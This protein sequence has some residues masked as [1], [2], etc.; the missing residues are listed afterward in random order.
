MATKDKLVFRWAKMKEEIDHSGKVV[1]RAPALVYFCECCMRFLLGALLSGAELFGGY[2][3][4][5]VGLVA[6]SGSGL[7]GFCAL[8]GAC[9]GY[10]SFQ[11]FVGGLRYVAAAILVFSVS[12]AFFDLRLYRLS[13]FM[14]VL[15]GLM[16]AATGFVYLSEAGWSQ[17]SIVYFLTEVVLTGVSCYFYA[18][19]LATWGKGR[20][21]TGVTYHQRISI[22][23]LLGTLLLTVT[24]LTLFQHLSV[25]HVVAAVVVMI[26]SYQG[27]LTGGALVGVTVGIGL[28][29][30]VESYSIYAMSYGLSGVMAGIAHR[31]GRG[32]CG[33]T[34][35]LS[36]AL[37]ILWMWAILPDV[38][39]LYEVFVAV[40]CFVLIPEPLL[41]QLEDLWKKKE[42]V[43]TETKSSSYVKD[44]LCATADGFRALHQ[45][46]LHA[47][48]YPPPNDND[49][50]TIFDRVADRVC[51]TCLL[52]GNCWH[53]DYVSTYNALNDALPTM[54]DRGSGESGDFPQ[55]FTHR[56]IHFADFLGASN[57]ELT[58]LRYRQQYQS[59]LLES[60]QAVC[61]QY[62][63]LAETLGQAVAQLEGGLV[64]DPV[65]SKK[66]KQHL[67]SR[68]ME[69]DSGV[70]REEG[71][72]L[73]L[74]LATSRLA[75]LT[76][77][78]GASALSK[79]V[80]RPLR[81]VE[82]D[83]P[84]GDR[85]LYVEEEPLMVVAG[86][87]AK[88][89]EGEAVS[90]DTGT[91]FKSENGMLYVLL[92][93]GMG[94]GV[95]A[96]TESDLAVQLLEQFLRAGVYPE[97]ALKTVAVALGFRGESSGGFTTVDLLTLNLFTGEGGLY[98]YGG[99]PTYLKQGKEVSRMAGGT[100]PMGIPNQGNVPDYIPFTVQDGHCILLASDGLVGGSHDLWV[101]EQLGAFDGGSPKELATALLEESCRQ[102]IDGDDR[103]V[104]VLKIGRRTHPSISLAKSK[105]LV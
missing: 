93:D 33:L 70:F 54:M 4:F 38:A 63:T 71:G 79:V 68:G 76:G 19:A 35:L 98:K 94:S 69:G 23:L 65:L 39:L 86:L 15:S 73:R 95:N 28:D 47:F 21:E 12:F 22:L 5:G 84:R 88:N 67:L 104:L 82:E 50:A 97:H 18:I 85:Q 60:R 36:S 81:L 46:L 30:T 101:R 96:H 105:K 52:Q 74:E 49:A 58:A 25:G 2:A 10:L 75:R 66:L 92:C 9:F 8:L 24:Q 44:R 59:R 3:P 78:A 72:R 62:G 48:T 90:G 64:H 16:M 6:C 7:E 40:L 34:Y 27:G 17:S 37:A 43:P 87:A 31:K 89:K 11:G 1:V 29:L 41:K 42:A 26:A 91:W 57:E 100:L 51:K 13:W 20:K 56:C 14:P 80:G 55:W 103:T 102:G 83:P 61:R 45:S 32:F 99:A 53:T 77:E